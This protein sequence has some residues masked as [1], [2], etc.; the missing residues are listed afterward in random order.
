MKKKIQIIVLISILLISTNFVSI[1]T[2]NDP[3]K[4]QPLALLAYYPVSHDFGD[5]KKGETNST[6]F[7]IWNAGCCSVLYELYE[8]EE[9]I[10]VTP[11]EGQTTGEH[12][13][14]TVIIE[15]SN[16]TYGLHTSNIT[17]SSN[18]GNGNF[19]VTVK[20]ISAIPVIDITVDEAWNL[21]TDTSNGIQIPVDV[22]TEE[23]WRAGYIDTPSPENP[24]H[25]SYLEWYDPNI[26]QDFMSTYDGQQLILYCG[27]GGRSK[28][29]ANMLA[30][31]NFNGIIY[32]ML[33]GLTEWKNK[34][35]PIEGYTTFQIMNLKGGIGS[36]SID[37]KNNGTYTAKNMSVDINVVGGLFSMIDFTSSCRNCE[38]PL[39]PNATKTE[40][41]SKD[42]YI[43]GFGSIQIT[44]SAW[45]KNA[46][47]ITIKQEG[48]VFGLLILIR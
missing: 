27:I 4:N 40:S 43:F 45:A 9:W 46:D 29:A 19:T 44:V 2:A 17:I 36:V 21:L 23:E 41:T 10:Q 39:A 34:G 28:N 18:A 5:V 30:E 22:R 26:L 38:N 48:F 1:S 12:D 6:T 47:K 16:L 32:N 7:E 11:T 24:R 35:Y 8:N 42:G 20:V 15:T 25:Y 14:I 37:I 3:L 31:N 13:I 33:G